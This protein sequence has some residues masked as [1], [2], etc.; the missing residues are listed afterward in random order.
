M[1]IELS[2]LKNEIELLEERLAKVSEFL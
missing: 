2:E 1:A